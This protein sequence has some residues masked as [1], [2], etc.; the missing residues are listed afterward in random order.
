MDTNISSENL[1]MLHNCKFR[2]IESIMK[3]GEFHGYLAIK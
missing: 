2:H 1:E 3:Y